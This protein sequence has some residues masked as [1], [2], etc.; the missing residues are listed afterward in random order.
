MVCTANPGIFLVQYPKPL[1]YVPTYT[2]KSHTAMHGKNHKVPMDCNLA[3]LLWL[4]GYMLNNNMPGN[5]TCTRR[6]AIETKIAT[7]G[8]AIVI[9]VHDGIYTHNPAINRVS[10]TSL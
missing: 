9:S 10:G 8:L 7:F 3:G 5:I 6:K 2:A 4:K 1:K